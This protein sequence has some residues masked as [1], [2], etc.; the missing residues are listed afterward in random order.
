LAETFYKENCIVPLR[1]ER[2][3]RQL[4]MMNVACNWGI[5]EREIKREGDEKRQKK[6][7][8]SRIKKY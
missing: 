1:N 5:N 4:Q 3:G 8:R 2:L 7:R 6:K